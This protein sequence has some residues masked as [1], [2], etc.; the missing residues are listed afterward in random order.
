MVGL[1]ERT[2]PRVVL[3]LALRAAPGAG[4]VKADD[5]KAGRV[6]QGDL[7]YVAKAC[8]ERSDVF[9]SGS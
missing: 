5:W 3:W 8:L 4:C 7:T 1:I 2:K 9:L 6:W